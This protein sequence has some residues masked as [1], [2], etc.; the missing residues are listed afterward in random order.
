[1]EIG[2]MQLKQGKRSVVEGEILEVV[3]TKN[4]Q[5]YCYTIRVYKLSLWNRVSF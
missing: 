2:Q 5:A 4:K 3:P 1:M